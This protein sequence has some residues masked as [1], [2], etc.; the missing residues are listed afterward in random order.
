MEEDVEEKEMKN[1][2]H[3]KEYR[4]EKQREVI[5]VNK[6]K[7]ERDREGNENEG[8]EETIKVMKKPQIG[9]GEGVERG[10]GAQLGK[11]FSDIAFVR[12]VYR[13]G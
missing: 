9:R 4:D 13:E 3:A 12:A 5:R 8:K 1:T 6:K 11:L 2:L 7:R 10:R